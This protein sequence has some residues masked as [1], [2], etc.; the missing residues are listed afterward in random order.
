MN[1]NLASSEDAESSSEKNE[2]GQHVKT[3]FAWWLSVA[4][5]TATFAEVA[6]AYREYDSPHEAWPA[7]DNCTLA[8]F[9]GEKA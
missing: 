4:P 9:R 2:R 6:Q 1:G 7:G 5:P 8:D 3:G